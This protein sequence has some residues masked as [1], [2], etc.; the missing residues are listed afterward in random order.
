M[1]TDIDWPDRYLPG[2]TD[3]F[4]SN[5]TIVANLTSADIWPLLVDITQW[6]FYYDNVCKITPPSSGP[7]LEKGDRFSFSTFGFPPIQTEVA[8]SVAPSSTTPGRLAW[9]AKLDGNEDEAIDVYHAWIV[10]DLSHGRVRI[11]TQ[12][13]QIGRPAIQL[14]AKKPNPIWMGHQDWLD[15]LVKTAR[16]ARATKA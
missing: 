13:S 3:L 2:L 6:E 15:G 5:E 14:A 16:E 10:E 1:T 4:V 7:I 8:E 12:E 9:I 11:F